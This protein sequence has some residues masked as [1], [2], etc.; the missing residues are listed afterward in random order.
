MHAPSAYFTELSGIPD[1][2]AVAAL[3]DRVFPQV[4]RYDFSTPG[5]ALVGLGREVASSALRQLMVCLKENLSKLYFRRAG[6]YLAYLSMARFDQKNTTKFHLDGAPDEAFLMLGYEPSAVDSKLAMADYSRAA[7][8]K[9]IEPKRFLTEFNPMFK[10][11]ASLLEPYVT[12]LTCFEP[13]SAQLLLI[14][15]SSLPFYSTEKNEL[16]VMHQATIHNPADPRHRVVNS[17]MITTAA[18]T[19]DELVPPSIQQYFITTDEIAGILAN[20]SLSLSGAKQS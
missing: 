7:F 3:A 15:N 12:R 17:T 6:K 8:D 4:F 5:F 1:L 16:G 20:Q 10:H 13:S 9:G 18:S 19:T 14:N 2:P 11:G